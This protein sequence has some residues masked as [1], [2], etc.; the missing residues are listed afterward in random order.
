MPRSLKAYVVFAA[1]CAPYNFPA[2]ATMNL[3]ACGCVD[4]DL[5]R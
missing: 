5:G 2:A 4:G 3:A 1:A